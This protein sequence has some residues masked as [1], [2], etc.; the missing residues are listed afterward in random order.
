MAS[1]EDS[2]SAELLIL[3]PATEANLAASAMRQRRVRGRGAKRH[4]LITP[5]INKGRLTLLID[6]PP[7]PG[8]RIEAVVLRA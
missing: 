3:S 2:V 5:G 6:E 4:L 8:R 1:T 7:P